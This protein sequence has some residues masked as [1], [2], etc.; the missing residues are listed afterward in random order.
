MAV[1]P[2]RSVLVLGAGASVAEAMWHRPKRD[3]DHPPLDA[4][5][6]RRV[7]RHPSPLLSRVV[8]HADRLGEADLLASDP[9]VS[10]EQHFGRLFFD[11]Q[12]DPGTSTNAAYYDLIRLYSD[13]LLSTTS[14]MS[15]KRSGPLRRVIEAELRRSQKLAIVTFNHDLLIENAL[16]HVPSRT[17]GNVWCTQ[18]AYGLGNLNTIEDESSDTFSMDC[19][20]HPDEHVPVYKLHGSVNW[21]FK[22]AAANPPAEAT[23]RKRELLIWTN[24]TIRP[25]VRNVTWTSPSGKGRGRWYLWSLIVPPI[26]EKGG[27]IRHELK[28]VWDSAAELLE[29]ADRVIFWGYSFP[30]ADVYSRYF[31][32]RASK[33]NDAL[34]RPVLINPDPASHHELW[35]VL[36]PISVEHYRDVRGY[37]LRNE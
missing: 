35:S 4:T 30:R 18:H 19:P 20:G 26:Y 3:R 7:S 33:R 9:P 25:N 5:F 6:F 28:G 15:D 11:M 31:F 12:T 32:Q 16:V 10:L 23:R 14:W 13:E 22:T 21:V 17:L 36:Q 24:R 37:L 29:E 1:A 2:R 34:R 27:F 8:Q